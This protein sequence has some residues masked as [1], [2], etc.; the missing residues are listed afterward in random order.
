MWGGGHNRYGY[1][2]RISMELQP[3]VQLLKFD[4]LLMRV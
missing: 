1:L 2:I 3:N 4:N